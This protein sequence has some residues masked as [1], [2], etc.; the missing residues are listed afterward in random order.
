MNHS[1]IV[2]SMKPDRLNELERAS[3][4]F[5][6][7]ATGQKLLDFTSG[8]N[9]TNLGWNNPEVNA[10]A[11]A[12]LDGDRATSLIWTKHPIQIE[13]AEALLQTLPAEFTSVVKATGGTE[14]NEEA[15]KIARVVTGRPRIIG[16]SPTYHGQSM[17]QLAVSRTRRP[18]FASQDAGLITLPFPDA[19]QKA[20]PADL[21]DQ[22]IEALTTELSRNDVAAL[23]IE[24]GI[25]TGHGT[26]AVAPNGFLARVR[27]L[28]QQHGTLLIIDEVGTGFSRTGRL[29][30]F[31]HA[32]I[33]PDLITFAKG[34]TNGVAPLG[35]VA[36]TESIGQQADRAMLISTFGGLPVSCAAALTT[37][38]IHQRDRIW[39]KAAA[40]GAAIQAQLK[41]A[42]SEHPAVRDV[43]GWGMELAL[44]L[45]NKSTA[46]HVVHRAYDLGLHIVYG[47]EGVIQLM[48]PLTITE[49]DRDAGVAMIIN[50][51]QSLGA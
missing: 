22:F 10:A 14:A 40:D 9:T 37:L 2:L 23:L 28:T 35:L 51:V 7:D 45:K 33:T 30:G 31:E 4:S 27:S 19:T 6:Y 50:A 26:V 29:F 46:A 32:G 21:L 34:L 12:I 49:A 18:A 47:D 48:P 13:L 5:I 25:V 8:W 42:L 1:R 15:M 43:R 38:K 16:L 24:P 36:L 39:E 41:D 11:R 3:G 20:Q 44:E 17:A